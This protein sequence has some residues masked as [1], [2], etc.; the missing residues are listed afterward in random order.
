M[1]LVPG[2]EQLRFDFIN[3][4]VEEKRLIEFGSN[5]EFEF[6]RVENEYFCM[7]NHEIVTIILVSERVILRVGKLSLTFL[8]SV[9]SWRV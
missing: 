3:I 7:L 5:V 4:K 6:L 1:D 2:W 8:Q 9:P